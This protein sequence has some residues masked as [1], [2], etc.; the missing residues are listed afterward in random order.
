MTSNLQVG[1]TTSFIG[2]DRELS[3]IKR[4]LSDPACRL[5]TLVGPGGI[6]K[7]RLAMEAVQQVHVPSGV[8]FVALQPLTTPD[9]IVST[10]A[11]ALGFQ[12]YTGAD[13]KQQLLD[14]LREKSL[15]IVL[16]NLEHLLTGV[17]LVSEILSTAPRVRILA[18]SRERLNLREEW[19][20]EVAG[21]S[22]P[23]LDGEF[24]LEGYSATD[25]FLQHASRVKVSFKL[26]DE[27]KP[28]IIR[29]CRLVEGMPLGIELAAGWVR[30]L[31]CEQIA[32]EIE[33]SLDILETPTRN[34]EPR[35]R[36]MR[37]VIDESWRLLSEGERDAFKKLA[38]FRGGFTRKAAEQVAGAALR[39]MIALV[40][41]SLVRAE[42][43]GRYDLHE[44]LRQY[45]EEKLAESHADQEQTRD[46]HCAFF[47]AFMAQ[48]DGDHTQIQ[49]KETVA[50]ILIEIK[51][52]RAALK[53]AVDGRKLPEMDKL[54]Q[55]LVPFYDFQA[56]Y[57]EGR[58]TFRLATERLRQA[59]N[60]SEQETRLL[61]LAL[62]W[63]A[64]FLRALLRFD[65][66]LRLAQESLELLLPL[67]SGREIVGAY[68]VLS[69]IVKDYAEAQ[70][71]CQQALN[72]AQEIDY[73]WGILLSTLNLSLFTIELGDYAEAL[74]VAE[75]ALTLCRAH[76]FRYGEAWAL[77]RL[78]DVA[79]AQRRYSEAKKWAAEAL[80]TA[81]A[82]GNREGTAYHTSALAESAYK[83]GDYAEARERFE[84]SL[85]IY[86]ELGNR[87]HIVLSLGR[88]GSVATKLADHQAAAAHL[89]EALR[90]TQDSENVDWVLIALT[91]VAE[92]MLAQG[93]SRRA[94]EVLVH[95]LE[96]PQST[97]NSPKWVDALHQ[98]IKSTLTPADYAA[99]WERGTKL[100]LNTLVMEVLAELRVF[101]QTLTQTSSPLSSD[102]LTEREMN[103]L[104]LIAAGYSNREIADQLVLAV[105]TVKWYINEIFSKLHVTTRVQAVACARTLGLLP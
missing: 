103:V 47:A 14:Y 80:A 89:A 86:Q 25:L 12:F 29:I 63:Q 35:H 2:R 37:A 50:Q 53:R 87:L 42:S 67:G 45:A 66:A 39:T 57:F 46:Q 5:L 48:W 9:L 76:E 26:T 3:E 43:S 52:V 58:E 90:I 7:T 33:R 55:A 71:L 82:V 92:L 99:A 38:V 32:S 72:C 6:G 84:N 21:L 44:L 69:H 95:Q 28:A 75:R 51:N 27:Q 18:T 93:N 94:L 91:H 68:I 64:W 79:F 20:L 83:S 104:R 88:L 74:R 81:Q 61:A 77:Q 15:L 4:L 30:A 10:I 102:L 11:D 36:T 16:D 31:S 41:K 96:Q 65:E 19:V 49:R 23:E 62:T 22:Y 100:E 60:S 85:T 24:D 56:W 8:Y 40:D 59:F 17:L 101:A 1:A 105:S 54:L 98:Q 97:N 78:A 73:H 13:P 70:R 34:T